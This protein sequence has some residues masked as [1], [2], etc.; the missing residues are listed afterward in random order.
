MVGSR[1]LIRWL[2]GLRN[3]LLRQEWFTSRVLPAL[4]RRV[5]WTL[6]RLYFLP[7]DLL[8]RLSGERDELTPPKSLV[9]TGSVDDFATSGAEQIAQFQVLGCLRPDSAVLDV[10]CGMGRLAVALLRS[11]AWDGVYEGL[12]IVPA[13]IK[14]CNEKIAAKD[15]RFRFTLADIYNREYNPD[16]TLPASQYRFPYDDGAFDLVVLVS[17][18]T[19]LLPDDMEHYVAEISRV[20]KPGGHCFASYNLLDAEARALMGNGR[21]MRRFTRVGPHWIVDAKVPELA[22]AYE[23]DYVHDLFD[24]HGLAPSF[25]YGTW[26]GRQLSAAEEQFGFC[27]DYALSRKR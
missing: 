1:K 15:P 4:P 10:G 16:G 25:H 26:S 20:L 2:Y 5:R 17:V 13:G 19:H 14:W 18:F 8:E 27:Q 23:D 7:S 6:R 22:V 21:A 3:W 11:D 9:F 24:R 12:D